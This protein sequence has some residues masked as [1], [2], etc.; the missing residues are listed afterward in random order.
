MLGFF[1]SLAGVDKAPQQIAQQ[2][3][4]ICSR[5]PFLR[6]P[7]CAACGCFVALKV[8]VLGERCPRGYW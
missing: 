4:S 6:G 2:R 1:K 8:K 5:C 3:L 7:R